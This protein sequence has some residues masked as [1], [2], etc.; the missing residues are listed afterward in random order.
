MQ[1][2]SRKHGFLTV[3]AHRNAVTRV[4]SAFAARMSLPL[5]HMMIAF[6][7]QLGSKDTPFHADHDTFLCC[8]TFPFPRF[9]L[10]ETGESSLGP[11]KLNQPAKIKSQTFRNIM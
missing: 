7:L 6:S 8:D 2:I 4:A 10:V 11:L 5:V 9:Y 3:E 1:W